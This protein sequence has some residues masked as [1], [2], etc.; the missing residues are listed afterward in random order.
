[1]TKLTDFIMLL[2]A[3]IMWAIF[4]KNL[5]QSDGIRRGVCDG[6]VY[7]GMCPQEK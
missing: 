3:V 1:M 7:Q 4:I 5:V 2:L 6:C